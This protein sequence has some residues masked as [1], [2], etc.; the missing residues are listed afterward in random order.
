MPAFTL[1][2][3]YVYPIKSLGGIQLTEALVEKRGLQYDRR[4][5]LTDP[6]GNFLT[7]RKF[8][9]MALL[10]VAITEAGLLVTHKQQ[11]MEP[12]L[13]PFEANDEKTKLVSIWNDVCFAFEI[14]QETDKW[15]SEALG[16]PCKLVHM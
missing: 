10:Q 16:M 4:W 5:M 3:I 1:S 9:Q 2:E 13:V 8:P 6:Q 14:S 7:Q 15:F 11:K 12:L